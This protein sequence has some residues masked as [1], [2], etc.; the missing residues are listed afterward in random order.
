MNV[1]NINATENLDYG[2][3]EAMN[4]LKTNIAFSGKGIKS[5]LFTSS[6]PNEGKSTTSFSLA[7]S[8][9]ESGKRVA[10][11]DA[12]MRKSVLTSRYQIDNIQDTMG[13]THYLSG[14]A[15]VTD[16]LC[17]TNI[18]NLFLILSGPLSPNPTEL[19]TG[20][21][22]EELINVLGTSLDYIIVDAPPLG[23]VIDAAI[24]AP[25][26]DGTII[27]VESG[28]AN[29]KAVL[30]VKKQLEVS[31]SKILGVALNKVPVGR[32]GYY[33]NKYYGEY[34]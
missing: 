23:A 13:L 24:M 32:K 21:S 4:T 7:C 31:G 34:K 29:R 10:F 3:R 26:C 30:N 9:A 5:I 19:L 25:K 20:N 33:N 22:W 12:D 17:G 18:R 14:Q 15:S 2:R 8:L 1:I 28:K 16:I 27:V 11:V 6:N